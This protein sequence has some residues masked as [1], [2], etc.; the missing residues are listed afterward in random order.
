MVK[1]TRKNTS[2]NTDS[3]RLTRY[4][5]GSS[6]ASNGSNASSGSS[7][8]SSNNSTPITV[9]GT[10]I[11]TGKAL[12]QLAK[13]TSDIT[14]ATALASGTVGLASNLATGAAEKIGEGVTAVSE[15]AQDLAKEGA[16]GIGN[17]KQGVKNF[18]AD[19]KTKEMTGK[20]FDTLTGER[21]IKNEAKAIA[22]TAS[23][24]ADEI[25]GKTKKALTKIDK[26]L[27][28][29]VGIN[30]GGLGNFMVDD[31][32]CRF[33]VPSATKSQIVNK[34]ESDV[35]NKLSKSTLFGD[36][37]KFKKHMTERILIKCREYHDV[38]KK[39]PFE[40][41]MR[42]F[43]HC[44]N[45]LDCFKDVT[46]LVFLFNDA[47]QGDLSFLTDIKNEKS[48]RDRKKEVDLKVEEKK[49]ELEEFTKQQEARREEE[50]KIGESEE[51]TKQRL[52]KEG[53]KKGEME[54]YIKAKQAKMQEIE[55]NKINLK[56]QIINVSNVLNKLKKNFKKDNK[57]KYLTDLPDDQKNN[58]INRF[59]KTRADTDIVGIHAE[60]IEQVMLSNKNPFA[61]M[62]RNFKNQKVKLENEYKIK[63]N[64]KILPD[65]KTKIEKEL[66]EI[67]SEYQKA[68]EDRENKKEGA[69]IDF[70]KFKAEE[71]KLNKFLIKYSYTIAEEDR[72]RKKNEKLENFIIFLKDNLV[73]ESKY[74][75][76]ITEDKDTLAKKV[77]DSQQYEKELAKL[78]NDKEK[79]EEI[80]K[81]KE[82]IK[83][84]EEEIDALKTK[85]Q[86]N[87]EANI[88]KFIQ[89][90]DDKNEPINTNTSIILTEKYK[91]LQSNTLS[92]TGKDKKALA[93]EINNLKKEIEK[94]KEE[95]KNNKIDLKSD[96][97]DEKKKEVIKTEIEKLEKE[98]KEKSDKLKDLN[99][100]YKEAD[101]TKDT[102]GT[103]SK[104]K[105]LVF[106]LN[107]VFIANVKEYAI[108][109]SSK[110]FTFKDDL[111]REL[112]KIIE[113]NKYRE[114]IEKLDKDKEYKKNVAKIGDTNFIDN[115]MFDTIKIEKR[116]KEEVPA[117][118]M[119][120]LFKKLNN[121]KDVKKNIYD[122]YKML[123]QL[124]IDID[125]GKVKMDEKFEEDKFG[126]NMYMYIVLGFLGTALSFELAN[127]SNVRKA[128]GS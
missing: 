58:L 84:A 44:T 10:A 95:L 112:S 3:N 5:G 94:A 56:K 111:S 83:N 60:V 81:K 98:I 116:D 32:N 97:V 68:L 34:T 16:E 62:K 74:I 109:N 75:K 38:N 123:M 99:K 106:F 29:T 22:D 121:D 2:R 100:D 127:L 21:L 86:K 25:S 18:A 28:K 49:K 103:D 80:D 51:E 79:K 105:I 8:S 40:E 69:I 19:E 1:K 23:L 14:G 72:L 52:E 11:G 108:V 96:K 120:D 125:S 85:I 41:F 67:Y 53:K 89:A 4:R 91:E 90:L 73:D 46:D 30:T 113:Y 115:K 20:V 63:L 102:V 78:I 65:I 39:Q 12:G 104:I 124:E 9:T 15:G 88:F 76:P 57:G 31:Q 114:Q 126:P 66:D 26:T 43:N 110:E 48:E 71:T 37:D 33:D 87:R 70:L 7:G 47:I 128:M 59:P 82:D 119:N 17:F 93:P 54:K 13:A 92:D 117:F 55:E 77:R 107:N 50:K 42:F 36:D 27:T 6:N 101:S 64:N 61:S 122:Y 45:L 35:S 24:A 118:D